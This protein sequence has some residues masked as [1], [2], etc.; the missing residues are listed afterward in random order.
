MF[1]TEQ[2]AA[3][4]DC[5]LCFVIS[6]IAQGEFTVTDDKTERWQ[7][8]CKQAEHEKDPGR[9]LA[10]VQEINRLLDARMES[11]KKER[12]EIGN[13]PKTGGDPGSGP[14]G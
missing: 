13:A 10:L 14:P 9:L 7:E 1:D 3:C 6:P 4:P 2:T 5:Y 12:P 8:L 11:F